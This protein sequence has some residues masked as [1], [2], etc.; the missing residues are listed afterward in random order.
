MKKIL[1]AIALTL[2]ST[3]AMAKWMTVGKAEGAQGFTVY[4]DKSSARKTGDVSTM[5]AMFDF[6]S[7]RTSKD[8]RY[9]SYKQLVEYDCK[10]GKSRVMEYSLHSK[11][12]GKGGAVYKDRVPGKWTKTVPNSVA[13][14]LFDIACKK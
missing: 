9:L 7:E 13:G 6:R 10:Q 2:F 14:N 3:G 5:W 1:I 12:M 4:A 11:H 8:F